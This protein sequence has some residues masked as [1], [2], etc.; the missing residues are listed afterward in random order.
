MS[1]TT[2]RGEFIPETGF[3]VIDQFIERVEDFGAIAERCDAGEAAARVDAALTTADVSDGSGPGRRAEGPALVTGAAVAIAETGTI[4]LDH[5]TDQGRRMR[6]SGASLHVC[7]VREHQIVA[8]V[9]DAV[10]CLSGALASGTPLTRVNGPR[11]NDPALAAV[12]GLRGPRHLH[13]IVVR[14]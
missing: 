10:A 7:V 1:A 2:I 5:G 3:D 11:L 14:D 9:D 4:I 8:G 12:E 13:V 6:A